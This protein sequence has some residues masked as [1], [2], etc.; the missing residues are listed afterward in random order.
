MPL[1]RLIGLLS[2]HSS[3]MKNATEIGCYDGTLVFEIDM[4]C[5]NA[6]AI[7]QFSMIESDVGFLL[8]TFSELV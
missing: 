2:I 3:E 7:F 6:M 1:K 5:D 4:R 8:R